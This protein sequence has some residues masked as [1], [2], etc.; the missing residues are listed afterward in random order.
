M[1]LSPDF[2]NGY[3]LGLSPDRLEFYRLA[4]TSSVDLPYEEDPEG[5]TRIYSQVFEQGGNQFGLGAIARAENEIYLDPHQYDLP[6]ENTDSLGAFEAEC[7]EADIAL[8]NWMR[9][10]GI[11]GWKKLLDQIPE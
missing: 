8:G 4:A 5:I 6:E 7:A 9:G 1:A 10:R 11:A 3:E 2:L